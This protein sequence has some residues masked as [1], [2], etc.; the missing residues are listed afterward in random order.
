M[1]GSIESQ[2]QNTSVLLSSSLKEVY[3]ALKNIA[4][5]SAEI[6]L[7]INNSINDMNAITD[8]ILAYQRQVEVNV[9]TPQ[10]YLSQTNSF[11]FAAWSINI[12]AAIL[13]I[14]GG[15]SVYLFKLTR[16]RVL[17]HVSWCTIS[18]LMLAGF[19]LAS[20]LVPLGILTMEGCDIYNDIISSK[21]EFATYTEVIPSDVNFKLQTCL[22][23]TGDLLVE[24]GIKNQVDELDNITRSFHKL[25]KLSEKNSNFSLS[26]SNILISAWQEEVDSLK[27]GLISD[28]I[29]SDNNNSFFSIDIFNKWSDY[30]VSGSFQSLSC[31]ETMDNWVFN[32][33][34]CTYETKW[35]SGSNP[36]YLYGDSVC[37][38]ME[39]FDSSSFNTRY[40]S[41]YSICGSNISD[42]NKNYFNSLKNYDTS[43]RILFNNIGIDLTNLVASSDNYNEKLLNFNDTIYNF[44]GNI[45]NFVSNISDPKSG[46]ISSFNCGFLRSSVRDSYNSMC[47]SLFVPI[48]YQIV[49]ICTTSLLMFFMSFVTYLAGMRFGKVNK[50]D[51]ID[52]EWVKRSD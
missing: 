28:Y 41:I 12:F 4:T 22:F 49:L 13:G 32:F 52:K 5:K 27:N 24:Y 37:I 47:V 25:S 35:I 7:T 3:M 20:I 45:E 38:P 18:I 8:S 34:N 16:M 31:S 42:N 26:S 51:E 10:D 39:D 33:S 14:F 30:G 46:L 48:Y 21:N 17:L 50:S 15:I 9:E 44:L 36:S 1:T 2:F 23:G 43:R 29:D 11:F 19:I 40:S 6:T